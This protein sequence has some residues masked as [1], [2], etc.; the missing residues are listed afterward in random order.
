MIR[1]V[2]GIEPRVPGVY[3]SVS[4]GILRAGFRTSLFKK[5]VKRARADRFMG[6][7]EAGAEVW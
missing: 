6:S 4:A 1:E 5:K 2:M 7:D 3:E